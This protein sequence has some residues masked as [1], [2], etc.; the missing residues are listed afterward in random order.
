M[1][2]IR[3][4]NSTFELRICG[5][6]MILGCTIFYSGLSCN[7]ILTCSICLKNTTCFRLKFAG[8]I[9]YFDCHRCFLPLDHPFRLDRNTF[10][11]DNIVL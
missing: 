4:K 7:G 10:K 8:K 3:S 11:K 9:S 2:M 6:S 1:T 5:R